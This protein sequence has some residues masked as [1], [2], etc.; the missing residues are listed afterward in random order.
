M[1]MKGDY[2]VGRGAKLDAKMAENRGLNDHLIF[3]DGR[4]MIVKNGEPELLLKD[5]TMPN[6]SKVFKHGHVS[7]KRGQQIGHE[8]RSE[9]GY[10]R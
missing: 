10:E 6:G 9:D 8:A 5:L 7:Y 3:R 2:Y 1:T 4:V